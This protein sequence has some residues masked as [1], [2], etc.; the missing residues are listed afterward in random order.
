[1]LWKL[2]RLA[3]AS[4]AAL[5]FAGCASA[6]GAAAVCRYVPALD[7]K[8]K[9]TQV[10]ADPQV[11]DAAV[12]SY[13][14]DDYNLLNL[15]T[16]TREGDHLSARFLGRPAEALLPASRTRFFQEGGDSSITLNIDGSGRVA[17][18]VLHR[19]HLRDV[20]LPRLDAAKAAQLQ[21]QLSPR[22]DPQTEAPRSQPALLHLL[23][24]LM[25]GNP[26]YSRMGIELNLAT[27]RQE[28]VIR[29]FL[30]D[31]GPVQSVQLLG[32]MDVGLWGVDGDTYDV[33]HKDGVSRWHIAV[34]DKGLVTSA[35]YRCGP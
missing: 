11:L 12:G 25:S 22:V 17:S 9:F 32:F 8:P 29:S 10:A 31:L 28:G 30:S 35:N 13:K 26:D 27:H 19:N 5:A 16:V 4:A 7:V 33:R 15:L 20:P 6:A 21:A 24:G 14:M 23:D 3:L 1:M 18:L 34:D 2:H